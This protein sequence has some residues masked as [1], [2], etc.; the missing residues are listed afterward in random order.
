MVE[1]CEVVAAAVDAIVKRTTVR[2]TTLTG[3][4]DWRYPQEWRLELC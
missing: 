2:L 1:A 3:T 4:D